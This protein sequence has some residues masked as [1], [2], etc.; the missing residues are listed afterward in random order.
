MHMLNVKEHRKYLF[1]I[2]TDIYN[3][4]AGKY[5]GFK[6]GTMLYYFYGLGR[7]SVDLDFD[8]L[9]ESKAV[10][11][12]QKMRKILEKYGTIADDRDKFYNIFF[13]LS[14]Q[15]G[16]HGIKIEIS[17]RSSLTQYEIKN[18]F[19]KSIIAMKIED[20][21][22]QKLV[23]ATDRKRMASRDFY[24]IYFLFKNNFNFNEAIIKERTQK[25]AREYLTF[26]KKFINKNISKKNILHGI[27]ELVD[28]KQKDWIKKNLKKELI[29]QI[30]FF[31]AEAGK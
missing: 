1:N 17:K 2:L 4:P 16:Q 23:A 3:S 21:F 13:L 5:L 18:F 9:D 11:V 26:L 29:S 20:A 31:L 30:D 15:K 22:A 7:F 14:Y 12:S 19:G 10:L 6:G 27:G 28:E 8:L 24:D 25:S